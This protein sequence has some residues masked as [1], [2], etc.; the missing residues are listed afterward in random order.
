MSATFTFLP[1]SESR[2]IA[3]ELFGANLLY[4]RDSL[5]GTYVDK[6]NALNIGQVRF[7]GGTL[8][9]DTFSLTS[10]DTVPPAR[11]EAEPPGLS[12]YLAWAASRTYP[13]NIIIPTKRFVD[14]PDLGEAAVRDFISGLAAGTWG[15]ADNIILEVGN[16]YYAVTPGGAAIS[17]EEYSRVAA[18]QVQII[19]ELFPEARVAVQMGK[20]D[21]DNTD[22]V[23][24]FRVSGVIDQIDYLV[25]HH[26]FFNASSRVR[27]FEEVVRSYGEW[28]E[29]GANAEIYMSAWNVAATITPENDASHDYGHKQV[30]AIVEFL[31]AAV[32]A[33]V[34][35]A[36]IW[37]IQNNNK[38][39]LTGNE[40]SN[41]VFATGTVY[42]LM[43][44]HLPGFSYDGAAH[45]TS[46]LTIH[47]FTESIGSSHLLLLSTRDLVSGNQNV[48]FEVNDS[49]RDGYV[50]SVTQIS[51]TGERD[52]PLPRQGEGA[53]FVNNG[54]SSVSSNNVGFSVSGISSYDTAFIEL[55]G[56]REDGLLIGNDRDNYI[57]GS[58]GND[59]IFGGSGDDVI[60]GL[61]LSDTI[62]G[63]DGNDLLYGGAGR[64]R[65]FGDAGNDTLYGG[66]G[67]DRLFGGEGDDWL[68]GGDGDD[69]LHV[70]PGFDILHGGAGADTFVFRTAD[71]TPGRPALGRIVDFKPSEGDTLD[72]SGFD[73]RPDLSGRHSGVFVG[74]EDFSEVGQLR[75]S[76][77][78]QRLELNIFD[79]GVVDAFVEILD[80][81]F[82]DRS[83]FWF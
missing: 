13:A 47:Q 42:G 66:D 16:E 81:D 62:H 28:Q 6:I 45:P 36:A 17:A 40:G 23:E 77:A 14:E 50:I 58:N 56:I 76:A 18:V 55:A 21:L 73:F 37:P 38:T 41:E 26:F 10:P 83:H 31:M 60:Y 67:N 27:R 35:M 52:M 33:D 65:L 51:Q 69:I 68:Y 71:L 78:N 19:S 57:R 64:D 70:G 80:A 44:E 9:E 8:A 1:T 48:A 49:F 20:G 61:R 74:Q 63:G 11:T 79:N 12:E 4:N 15:P 30:A 53:H 54:V 43:A 24:H 32:S 82:V 72:F 7:P 5:S 25:T 22:I 3:A 39:M 2:P 34:R 46:G 29:A 75:W 59:L